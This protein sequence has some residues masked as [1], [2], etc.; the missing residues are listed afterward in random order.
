MKLT[1]LVD[2][3]TNIDEYYLG[4]PGVSYYIEDTDA[5]VLFD[6]GYS[7]ILLRNAEALH[8]EMTRVSKIVLSHGHDDHTRGLKFMQQEGLLTGKEI[9][10]HPD[11]FWKKESDGLSIGAPFSEEELC[12]ITKLTLVREP[13]KISEHLTYLA[14]IPQ[15]NAF[16]KR[17]IIGKMRKNGVEQ[18]DYVK[19]DSALVY[20]GRRGL[21]IITGC[22]HSGICNIIEYAKKVCGDD[23]IE[24][25]IGGFHL[26]ETTMTPRLQET[27]AYFQKNHIQNLSPC[28]CVS[29]EAK[30]YIHQAIPIHTV[31]VGMQM[32]VI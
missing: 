18:D 23:R 20:K 1:V 5:T 32:E 21:T 13:I 16:E 19:E 10:A 12:K 8:K 2:N 26:L 15:V 27:I 17:K 29:F 25:I 7:D 31:G 24:G 3:Y 22:S 9:I 14:E 30:A 6:T 11:T 4:E 28:H